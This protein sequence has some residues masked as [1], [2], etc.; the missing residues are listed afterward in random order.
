M[1]NTPHLKKSKKGQAAL[2]YFILFTAIAAGTLISM[3]VLWPRVRD[4]MQ[5]EGP[6]GEGGF[7]YEVGQRLVDSDGG[8]RGD[9]R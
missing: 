4:V 8:G 2:E 6:E 5:G 3:Q 7:Y 9:W 1:K